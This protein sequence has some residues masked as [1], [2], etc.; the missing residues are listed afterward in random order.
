MRFRNFIIKCVI[1]G[2]AIF[3]MANILNSNSNASNMK[4]STGMALHQNPVVTN[5][6]DAGFIPY[7]DVESWRMSKN[8]DTVVKVEYFDQLS[9]EEQIEWMKTIA[10]IECRYLGILDSIPDIRIQEC[11]DDVLGYYSFNEDCIA[12]DDDLVASGDGY[13]VLSVMEHELYHRYQHYQ[14][15]AYE[16]LKNSEYGNLA[17]LR[18][19][20]DASVYEEEFS[21]YIDADVDMLGYYIQSVECDSRSYANSGMLYEDYYQACRAY[22]QEKGSYDPYENV[23]FNSAVYSE[24]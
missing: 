10:R 19:L 24:E 8:M 20:Y 12:V 13:Y 15:M 6:K 22:Y 3:S 4:N 16:V 11:G 7:D 17:N 23:Y 9:A 14:V 1:V 5:V 21:D 18:I 2:T